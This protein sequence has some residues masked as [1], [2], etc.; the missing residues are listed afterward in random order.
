[1]NS[2]GKN[3]FVFFGLI[4]PAGPR[5]PL[6][7]MAHNPGDSPLFHQGANPVSSQSLSIMKSLPHVM[8]H[9]KK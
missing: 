8:P 5:H 1:M 4:I 3:R 2:M 6:M 7:V 9:G